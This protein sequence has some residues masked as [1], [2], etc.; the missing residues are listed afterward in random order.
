MHMYMNQ[1]YMYANCIDVCQNNNVWIQL[2]IHVTQSNEKRNGDVI[3]C[4][5]DNV[6]I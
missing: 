1:G 6:D 5:Y 3:K 2:D 4:T